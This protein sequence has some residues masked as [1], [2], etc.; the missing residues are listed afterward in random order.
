M[1]PLLTMTRSAADGVT[2]AVPLRADGHIIRE[3][4]WAEDASG[5]VIVDAT[6]QPAGQYSP[7]G[8]LLW[9]RADGRPAIDL[10]AQ[11]SFL[12]WGK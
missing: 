7:A 9:L 11:G 1:P 6:T 12:R 2:S 3:A 10:T 8:P 4:L 5:A